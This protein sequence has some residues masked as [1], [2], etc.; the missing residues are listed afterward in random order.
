[1]CVFGGNFTQIQCSL[2]VLMFRTPLTT[3][4]KI[5]CQIYLNSQNVN[6]NI[7]ECQREK[8]ATKK[9]NSD[10]GIESGRGAI[11]FLLMAVLGLPGC[12]WA[13]LVVEDRPLGFSNCGAGA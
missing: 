7:C 1:M 5:V 8:S 11:L 13:S 9:N 10:K 12:V 2:Q 4:Q 3:I 6:K